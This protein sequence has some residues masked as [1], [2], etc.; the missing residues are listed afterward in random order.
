MYHRALA[1]CVESP[2][3]VLNLSIG[4]PGVPDAVE[5]SLFDQLI[6][7]GVTICAAMGNER[8]HGSPT[9]YPA[10]IPGVIAVGATALDDSVTVF[11]NS[12]NHIALSAP[13]KAIWSTL[14]THPGQTG[15]GAVVAPNGMPQQG[16]PMRRETDYD[17][18]DGTS[19]A[20]PHVAGAAALLLAKN[21]GGNNKMTP[22]Q[23]RRA[24]MQSADKVP[25]MNGS[26]F[27]SDYGAG[28]LN[29]FK[30]L[31]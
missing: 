17:A 16:K 30:L 15:F 31:Q 25:E 24:L 19:M 29:L 2:V 12:G 9:S 4:G 28:R 21:N 7:A 8:Q 23:V 5:R 13:G 3:D 14:P 26:D 11:S 1:A 20:T 22:G 6:A 27:S 10:A 18:W